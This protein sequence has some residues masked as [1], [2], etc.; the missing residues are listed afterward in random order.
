MGYGKHLSVMLFDDSV[1]IMDDDS[2][3]HIN[4]EYIEA[5]IKCLKKAVAEKTR[6]MEK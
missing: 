3:V 4:D 5:V 2:S 6:G 1:A